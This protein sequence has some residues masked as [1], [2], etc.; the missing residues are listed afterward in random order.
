MRHRRV[1]LLLCH[2]EPKGDIKVKDLN[3]NHRKYIEQGGD[4]EKCHITWCRAMDT[5]RKENVSSAVT[6]PSFF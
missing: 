5:F 6:S 4:C 2:F 1:H 3:L